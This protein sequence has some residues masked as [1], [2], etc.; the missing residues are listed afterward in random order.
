[1]HWGAWWHKQLR[2]RWHSLVRKGS[3]SRNLAPPAGK[4]AP[5]SIGDVVYR[6]LMDRLSCAN[7]CANARP[8]A[9][10]FFPQRPVLGLNQRGYSPLVCDKI[11][12]ANAEHKSAIKAQ[13]QLWKLAEIKVSV[14]QI[15]EM[16]GEIGQELHEHLQTQAE[17]HRDQTLKPQHAE[18]PNCV[19]V[20]TDGG[21]IMTRADAGRRVHEQAWK[22]TKNACLMTMSSTPSPRILTP[23][24]RHVSR[25]ATMSKNWCERSTRPPPLGQKTARKMRLFPKKRR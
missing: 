10:I 17:A 2:N 20:S 14:P 4:G 24:F 11:V 3:P 23:N 6:P 1:M 9:E 25:I 15:I 16:S 8:V 5:L 13:K 12:S 21:R 22:E 7:P 19:A 18:P